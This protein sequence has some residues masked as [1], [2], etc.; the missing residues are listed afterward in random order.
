MAG[1]FIVQGAALVV[2][3]MVRVSQKRVKKHVNT[4]S[5]KLANLVSK[6]RRAVLAT[7]KPCLA[8]VSCCDLL[9]PG[10]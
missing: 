2:A 8:R 5:I 6:A 7:T 9:L 10:P 3:V 4:L 1:A